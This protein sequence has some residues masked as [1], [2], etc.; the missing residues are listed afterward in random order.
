MERILFNYSKDDFIYSVASTATLNNASKFDEELQRAWSHARDEGRFRYHLDKLETEIIPGKYSFVSQL[1]VERAQERRKPEFISSITESFNPTRFN[2][3]K[4]KDEEILFS[5]KNTDDLRNQNDEDL[6]AINVSPYEYCCSLFISAPSLCLP[7][8]L[9]KKALKSAVEIVLLSATPCMKV[10]F[11]SLGGYAS[12][13]HHHFHS[14][15]LAGDCYELCDYPAPGFA[16]ELRDQNVDHLI[17]CVMKLADFCLE[18]AVPHNLMIT[19]GSLLSENDQK[20]SY[21]TVRVIFWARKAAF[22]SASENSNHPS[23]SQRPEGSKDDFA[24]NP[25]FCEFA[26]HLPIK[27]W[28]SLLVIYIVEVFATD[29]LLYYN[30]SEVRV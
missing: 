18:R 9:Q 28:F 13:N 25:A 5:M 20:D 7:Q 21:D 6:L 12:V 11:N 4:I 8:I 16:F 10:G 17:S 19:R 26:G 24:F 22:V 23:S 27:G 29:T 14:Q 15:L 3:N 1:N 2:F 30:S